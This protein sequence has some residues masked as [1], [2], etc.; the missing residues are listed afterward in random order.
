MT[1]RPTIGIV[2]AGNLGS[3][4][5][6][7]LHQAGYKIAEVVSRMRSPARARLVATEVKARLLTIEAPLT[8]D[9]LWFCVPDREIGACAASIAQTGNWRGKL[10]FHSSGALTS[11]ELAVLR[12]RGTSVASVHPLMTFVKGVSPTLND[13]PFALEGDPA[14]LRVARTIVRS[15]GG[16]SFAIAKRYKSAYHAWGAFASPLYVALLVTAE[17][18]ARAAGIA[19]I[20]A[21]KM[22]FPILRQTLSNYAALGPAAAFSG[23]IVRGDLETV[24]KHLRILSRVPEAR[25]VYVALARSA[26]RDLPTPD[27]TALADLLNGKNRRR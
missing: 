23:P 22:M 17:R 2:G 3:V 5:A 13:I 25:D 27:R 20:T 4:L 11:D 14:A 16:Q 9:L 24:S 12:A 7:A 10:A 26:L 15:L 19:R 21:R 18:V 6:S 1:K 8:S